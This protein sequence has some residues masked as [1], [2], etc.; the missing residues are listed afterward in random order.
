MIDSTTPQ[1]VAAAG[2]RCVRRAVACRQRLLQEPEVGHRLQTGQRRLLEP[3][4]IRAD[5]HVV[6]AAGH[7]HDAIDVGGQRGDRILDKDLGATRWLE[8]LDDRPA[9][10]PEPIGLRHEAERRSSERRPFH[11]QVSQIYAVSRGR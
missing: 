11:G 3:V 5:R 6:P 10:W 8:R 9:S 4:E 2:A 7:V 1:R